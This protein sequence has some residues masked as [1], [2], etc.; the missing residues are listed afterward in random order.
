MRRSLALCRNSKGAGWYSHYMKHGQEGFVKYQPPT[1]FD[2]D[3]TSSG[4]F[5]LAGP[6]GRPRA[7]FTMRLENEIL[8][9]LTFE[10]AKDVVPKTVENFARLVRGEG[11]VFKGYQGT[12]V[13]MVRKGELVM[14]GDV[15]RKADFIG[16]GNHSSYKERYITDENFIIPHSQRGL[17]R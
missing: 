17:L 3:A 16:Q 4:P 5:E 8:G 2:W 11:E 10:L 6:A 9:D 15:E 14:A 7:V 1:A 13:H 12:G